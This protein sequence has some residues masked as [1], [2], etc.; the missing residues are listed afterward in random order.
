M[1]QLVAETCKEDGLVAIPKYQRTILI[2]STKTKL[3]LRLGKN[4][5][6]Q[7]GDKVKIHSYHNDLQVLEGSEPVELFF[8]TYAH[9]LMMN[10][11][12]RN[13][14]RLRFIKLDNNETFGSVSKYEN[15]RVYIK[16]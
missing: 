1:D 4:T 7:H 11:Q 9:R 6:F 2:G 16:K 5:R 10:L 12:V 13:T 15:R 8:D 14:K 3:K